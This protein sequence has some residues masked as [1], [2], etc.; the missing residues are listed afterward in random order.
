[1]NIEMNHKLNISHLY[2]EITIG[3]M[4]YEKSGLHDAFNSS[5]K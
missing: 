1:M 5:S 3:Q 4:Q 2:I